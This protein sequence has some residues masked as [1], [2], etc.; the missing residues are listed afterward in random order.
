MKLLCVLALFYAVASAGHANVTLDDTSPAI[1]Y[2]SP[3]VHCSPG[4]QCDPA[5]LFNG[6]SSTTSSPVGVQ[7]VGTAVYVY[8]GVDGRCQINLDGVGVE[9]AVG[10]N[11]SEIFLAYVNTSMVDGPHAITL[12][13]RHTTPSKHAAAIAGGIVGGVVLMAALSAGTFFLRRRQKQ[14]R[15][16]KRGIP[17]GDYWP[18]KPSIQLAGMPSPK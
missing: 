14:R 16:A 1:V 13:E 18:D 11:A 15:I 7:F 12:H 3:P 4:T 10:T 6:T 8:L 2:S 9:V 17:L 5:G